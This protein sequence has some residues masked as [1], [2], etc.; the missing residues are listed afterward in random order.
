MPN[1]I[2]LLIRYSLYILTL[3]QRFI[4]YKTVNNISYVCCT[5]T[6]WSLIDLTSISC[7]LWLKTDL[8]RILYRCILAG[9]WVSHPGSVRI[10]CHRRS[11]YRHSVHISPHSLAR[12]FLV[13]MLEKTGSTQREILYSI[14]HKRIEVKLQNNLSNQIF[15]VHHENIFISNNRI[16]ITA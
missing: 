16:V 15:T 11:G 5:G 9:T 2:K 13:R 3:Y 1:R 10:W 6:D 14:W 7:F 8:R 4:S 12:M